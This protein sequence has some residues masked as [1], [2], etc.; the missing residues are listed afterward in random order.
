MVRLPTLI[1]WHSC[2]PMRE[3]GTGCSAGG[4]VVSLGD[5]FTNFC[6]DRLTGSRLAAVVLVLVLVPLT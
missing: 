5:S 4:E 2:T 3:G 1:L 6:F